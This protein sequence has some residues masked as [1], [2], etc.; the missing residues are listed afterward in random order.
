MSIEH[1]PYSE[2][3]LTSRLLKE[4]LTVLQGRILPT[5]KKCKIVKPTEFEDKLHQEICLDYQDRKAKAFPEPR[6]LS[7]VFGALE[8]L[9]TYYT[10]SF[11]SLLFL[12]QRMPA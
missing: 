2:K 9:A 3:Y 4:Y 7:Y 5:R 12:C 10:D 8:G 1:I 6:D 11:C